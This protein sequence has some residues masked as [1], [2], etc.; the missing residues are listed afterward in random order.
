MIRMMR[1]E[2]YS[3]RTTPGPWL[4]LLA[5]G[6]AQFFALLV[7]GMQGDPAA[8]WAGL[9]PSAGELTGYPMLLLG[10][11]AATHEHRFR[12]IVPVVLTTPGRFRVLTAKAASLAMVAALAAAVSQTFWLGTAVARH[13]GPAMR[14]GHL[15]DLARLYAFTI[16]G[17][18]LLGLFGVALGAIVRNAATAFVILP[19]G[20]LVE[21]MVPLTRYHGPF[22]SGLA[23]FGPNGGPGTPF[24]TG[25]TV[26]ALAFAAI[27][28]RWDI[29]D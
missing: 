2:L 8:A 16:G 9:G 11:M 19:V 17:V 18:V 5:V 26:V 15:A 20:A 27:A 21:A 12:T 29:T 22:T 23:A 14:T 24:L 10:V 4:T 3:L 7:I 25:W 13:G 28:V 6:L 1:A